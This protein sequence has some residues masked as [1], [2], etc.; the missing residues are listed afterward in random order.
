MYWTNKGKIVVVKLLL[1]PNHYF[2]IQSIPRF[3]CRS[4]HWRCS[5]KGVLNNFANSTGKHL[6]W[7][8]FLIKFQDAPNFIKKRLQHRRFPVKFGKFLRVPI[9]KKIC[10]QLLLSMFIKRPG[11]SRKNKENWNVWFLPSLIHN[12]IS[13]LGYF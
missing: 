10:E 2:K 8:L 5:A 7:S 3:L 13:L 11:K 6:C 12:F 1:L 9:I 4:S